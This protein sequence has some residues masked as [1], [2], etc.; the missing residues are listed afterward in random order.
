MEQL[1]VIQAEQKEWSERNF[2]KQPSHR[3]LLGV[4]E[5]LCELE[6]AETTEEILDAVGDVGIYMS[7]YCNKREWA[8][9]DLWASAQEAQPSHAT[10]P[11]EMIR[12][13]AHSQLKGEQ[14]IRGGSAAHDAKMRATL[15]S[16]LVS[17]RAHCDD[18]GA[19]FTDVMQKVWEK[20][21]QRNW[22]ANPDTAHTLAAS[23]VIDASKL[24]GNTDP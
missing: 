19:V 9:Q 1:E 18:E 15:V 20:V 8:M 17:M 5:E 23:Q 22:V 12:W 16:V 10:Y 24:A 7:D 2:G 6:M 11:Y 4:I 21:K 3:P 14:N 13:L